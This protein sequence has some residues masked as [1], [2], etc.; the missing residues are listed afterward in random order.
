[1]EGDYDYE[2]EHISPLLRHET[3]HENGPTEYSSLERPNDLP[4]TS[5]EFDHESHA[6]LHSIAE[7]DEPPYPAAPVR[8]I[9]T[10]SDPPAATP[11]NNMSTASASLGEPVDRPSEASNAR[12]LRRAS[13][14]P[15]SQRRS[16]ISDPEPTQPHFQWYPT[17][18]D[19]LSCGTLP[20]R[21]NRNDDVQRGVSKTAEDTY[22]LKWAGTIVRRT[23]STDEDSSGGPVMGSVH[24]V[25]TTSSQRRQ[26]FPP[27]H[28]WATP[29]HSTDS[30]PPD[31]GSAKSS[32]AEPAITFTEVYMSAIS[33]A[34]PMSLPIGNDGIRNKTVQII[35]TGDSLY[36]VVWDDPNFD[37]GFYD[38]DSYESSW[39]ESDGEGDHDS[40]AGD[41]DDPPP[42]D[43]MPWR[44]L[45]R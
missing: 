11:A 17:P 39:D 28:I 9:T 13:T 12:E 24:Q 22:K 8:T 42:D 21:A 34:Q 26:S 4:E 27:L 44:N 2:D 35:E 41:F 5:L 33:S 23:S 16:S 14:D 45:Q 29:P 43:V 30:S 40:Q 10:S 20:E 38:D 7:E 31:T 18:S 1:M 15:I 6:R 36:E 37:N 25:T 3:I 32:P 19:Q